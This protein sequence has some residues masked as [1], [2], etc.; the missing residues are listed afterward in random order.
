MHRLAPFISALSVLACAFSAPALGQAPAQALAPEAE[1]ALKPADSFRE[2]D[3]CP[4]M[5]VVPAGSF[6]MGSPESEKGRNSWEGPQHVVTFARPFA[7]GKFEVTV[8]Q[9]AAFVRE[10]GYDAGSTCWT[11]EDAKFDMRAERSWRNPGFSQDGSH[12]AACLSWNDA[13]AYADWLAKKTGGKGYRLLSEAEWEYAARA[14]NKPGSGPSFSFGIDENAICAHA[15]GLDQT[16]KKT[17]PGTDTWTFLPCSDGYATTAPAGKFAANGF[18]LYDMQG[19]VKEWTLDCYQ[20]GLG[21]RGAPTD[22]SAWTSGNC[23]S[24]VLRGGSWLSYARLLRVAFRSTGAPGERRNDVG[25]R[26][27]RTLRAP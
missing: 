25:I 6:T 13:K 1:R 11:Y 24:R 17:F 5:V 12:P 22:G 9:L 21:Y 18:G 4:E 19:N 10:T 20:E 3:G 27:A 16:A 23:R 26:V 8:D 14:R 2:C 7:V 15:D